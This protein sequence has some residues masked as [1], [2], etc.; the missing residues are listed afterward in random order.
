VTRAHRPQ[1]S[2]LI[3]DQEPIGEAAGQLEIVH[4]DQHRLPVAPAALA[5]IG[6]HP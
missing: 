1:R 5:K 6:H 2:T 4:G 3:H